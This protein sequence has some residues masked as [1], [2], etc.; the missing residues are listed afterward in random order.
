MEVIQYYVA[1]G[2]YAAS[3]QR[4]MNKLFLAMAKSSCPSYKVQQ[5]GHDVLKVTTP[6]E[7]GSSA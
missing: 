2:L 4:L 1:Y 3:E 6:R 5:L 7:R